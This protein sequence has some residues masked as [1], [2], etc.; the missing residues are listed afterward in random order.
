MGLKVQRD[1]FGLDILIFLQL[2][3]VWRGLPSERVY[4]EK[5]IK[6]RGNLW[7]SQTFQDNIEGFEPIKEEESLIP[8]L[9][10]SWVKWRCENVEWIWQT[11]IIMKMESIPYFPA[12]NPPTYPP[13]PISSHTILSIIKSH[14]LSLYWNLKIIEELPDCQATHFLKF[15][16]D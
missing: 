16:Q 7:R 6:P 13:L 5:S 11:E 8:M 12:Q 1:I 9:L 15:M 2:A 4:V 3:F 10:R 14:T